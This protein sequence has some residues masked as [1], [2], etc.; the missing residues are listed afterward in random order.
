MQLLKQASRY[1]LLSAL[2]LGGFA[3]EGQSANAVQ[4]ATPTSIPLLKA[5]HHLDVPAAPAAPAA[6]TATL[7]NTYTLTDTALGAFQNAYLPGSI[8]N[9]RKVRLGGIG[10]DMWHSPTDP[11]DEF[12]MVTDR[13]P[14]VT[15][16]NNLIFA[17]PTF[18]PIILHVRVTP[19][20]T[21]EI[22]NTYPI[23]TAAGAPV[24]GLPNINGYD[25]KPFEVDGTT[26]IPYNP[27][28]VDTEGLVR[29]A[30]GDF[31]LVE[32]YNPSLLHLDST[33]K[34]IRRYAP[35]GLVFTPTQPTSP[36]SYTLPSIL[37]K[38]KANRGFESLTM[39]HDQKWLYFAVQ[40]PLN[41]PNSAAGNASNLVRVFQ[42]DVALDRVVAEYVYQFDPPS[43]YEAGARRQ[44]LKV[45]AMN[46]V[47][48]TT[49]LIEERTDLIAKVYLV[50]L[51]H[52]TNIL[53]SLWDTTATSPTLEAYTNTLPTGVVPLSKTLVVNLSEIPGMPNKIEGVAIVNSTTLAVANDNDFD[54]GTFD[55]NGDNTVITSTKSRILMIGL[56]MTLPLSETPAVPATTL[57]ILHTN[58]VHARVAEYNANGSST[59]SGTSCVGGAARIATAV[60]QIRG[61]VSNTMLLDAGDQFQGTLYYNLFKSDIVT[62]TMNAIGYDAM[63]I[64]NHEF[65]D[66]PAE[67]ERLVTGVNF[68]VLSSNINAST[69]PTLSSKIRASV[70][71][72]K[73]GVPYGV[74]GATTEDTAFL[75][76]VGDVT[77]SP[78]VTAVQSEVNKLTA[79]GISKIIMV[80]H[81]GYDV[82]LKLASVITGV[83]V[84]VGGHTH[85]FLYTPVLTRA[86]GDVP[87]GPYPTVVTGKDGNPVLIV[88]AFQ[89]GRYLGRIDVGFTPTGTVQSW[90]GA[91]ILLDSL[92][93]QDP[94]V[95]GII[96]PTYSSQVE[97]LR[98]MVIGT[99]TVP[100]SITVNSAPNCRIGECPLGN[101]LADAM[102]WKANQVVT[103]TRANAAAGITANEAPFDFALT[104]GG[105][106]RAPID[107]GPI[108]L[109]E[110]L[111][112]LPF[113]NSLATF[114]ITGTHVI[115]SI[116][117]GLARYGAAVSGNGRFPQVS[118]LRFFFDAT[119]PVGQRLISVFVRQA[120]GSYSPI[121]PTRVYR[122]VTNNFTR[123]G[124][125]DYALFRDAAI[126]PYDFGPALDQVLAD[127]IQSRPNQTISPAVEGRIV[128]VTQRYYM[129][130]VVKA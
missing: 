22:L 36:V 121:V 7:L 64:G 63:T 75:S 54:I 46:F 99:S 60:N 98:T 74:V 34:T 84:I 10:S 69:H 113:G 2:L 92:V 70:I 28:G 91:P 109:G 53:G 123:G 115:T 19:T 129:P 49:L 95:L 125:D 114:E 111:E 128:I 94:A 116:E 62:R 118:G 38:R 13:G 88:Q 16:N 47:N 81:L 102:L 26:L 43:T 79:Q 77:F 101:L 55:I 44:D 83:D 3:T 73:N 42:F 82:D 105:G 31:W 9:D 52:A 120:D 86:N 27:D 130:I 65:D 67:L 122:I 112:T 76:S 1:A 61:A 89:W 45:S 25:D 15:I 21:I 90:Q 48:P 110:V 78:V 24:T 85:T 96:T 126:N 17:V 106:L 35:Q 72:T 40:S 12:W 6:P 14:N 80:G 57:T 37:T 11:A 127:Y 59:C 32:E 87:A 124:G 100:L 39:S 104:N 8:T 51:T 117:N 30:S 56:T 50:D 33:G 93:P 18:D 97:A 4:F 71:I 41:N 23:L 29:T 5:A 20:S 68:P 103:G 108:S 58:D 66:K 107:V 119:R